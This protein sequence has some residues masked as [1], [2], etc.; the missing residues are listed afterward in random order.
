MLRA[1][2]TP[3]G[4][5]RG[6]LAS[7]G[8]LYGTLSIASHFYPS[9]SGAYEANALFREQVFQTNERVMQD[10]YTVHAINYTEAPNDYGTTV[11]IG[12]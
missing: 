7:R 4:T 10:D 6:E 8:T 11:T 12:G 5:L 2:L 9:Y 1:E 3:Q